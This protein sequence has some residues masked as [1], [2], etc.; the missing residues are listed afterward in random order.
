MESPPQRWWVVTLLS[1]ATVI[2]YLDR[3]TLG[4]LAP[5]LRD[6]FHMSNQY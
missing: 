3:Q 4:V 5:E 6:R 1:S 2:D